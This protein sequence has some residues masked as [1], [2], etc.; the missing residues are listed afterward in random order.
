MVWGWALLAWPAAFPV[1]AQDVSWDYQQELTQALELDQS[2][3]QSLRRLA[4]DAGQ[5]L[6]FTQTAGLALRQ[7]SLES[8]LAFY[9]RVLAQHPDNLLALKGRARVLAALNRRA[10]ALEAYE[11]ALAAAPQDPKLLAERQALQAQRS[12]RLRVSYIQSR[13]DEHW[14]AW[15]QK[16]Y[17]TSERLSQVQAV[18]PILED[19]WLSLGWQEGVEIQESL[20]FGDNDYALNRR[21]PFVHL[22]AP[23]SPQ[24]QVQARLRQETF[25]NHDQAS[26][27]RQQ[28]KQELWTGYALI[29]YNQG[30][31]SL[32]TSY[33]RDRD[34]WPQFDQTQ[35]RGVLN[36]VAQE[37]W[38]LSLAR[39]LAP[40]WEG[41]FSLYY[42]DYGT[43]RPDQL[44]VNGQVVHRPLFLPGLR[45]SLGA[46]H[47][48]EE[49]EN[50]VQL[51]GAYQWSPWSKAGLELSYA[52]EYAR[53][54]RSWLNLAQG[55]LSWEVAERLNL[56]FRGR[57]GQEYN[58]D[59]DQYWTLDLGLEVRL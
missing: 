22:T 57:W 10:Q 19:K 38:G 49:A 28:D 9:Q 3:D 59:R 41:V 33:T 35:G 15:G 51:K 12:P 2:L 54:E 7:E 18:L 25:T 31:W 20:I 40:G 46:G 44:N 45:L 32:N 11:Q 8:L 4:L 24:L 42:E 26:F 1:M 52:L 14:P 6:T 27:Y 21:G 50:L 37:L 5:S 34:T 47:Y 53:N 58:G 39:Y 17:R 13:W 55:L 23:L 36:I 56:L 29:E 16:I 43:D 30:P 48:T